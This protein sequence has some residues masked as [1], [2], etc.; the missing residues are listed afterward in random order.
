M[1]DGRIQGRVDILVRALQR[2]VSP[3]IRYTTN[4]AGGRITGFTVHTLVLGAVEIPA[5]PGQERFAQE[6]LLREIENLVRHYKPSLLLT[7]TPDL[8]RWLDPEA[9]DLFLDLKPEDSGIHRFGKEIAIPGKPQRTRE[10]LV[11]VWRTGVEAFRYL[12]VNEGDYRNSASYTAAQDWNRSM[13]TWVEEQNQ[14]P[15]VAVEKLVSLNKE[16]HEQLI[17]A[18]AIPGWDATIQ[19]AGD[20]AEQCVRILFRR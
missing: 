10:Q 7:P 15:S 6:M 14:A 11:F 16:L 9:L 18:L 17:M 4:R 8:P 2:G 19:P 1:L 3:A 5:N 12:P 13:Y 20:I